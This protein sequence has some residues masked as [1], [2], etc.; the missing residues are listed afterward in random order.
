MIMYK[1]LIFS[2]LHT[3]RWMLW[4]DLIVFKKTFFQTLFD[5]LMWPCKVVLVFGYV[6]PALG[7]GNTYGGFNVISNIATVGVFTSVAYA[8]SILT[9]L[10]GDRHLDFYLTLPV[11][12]WVIFLREILF[13]ALKCAILSI[14]IYPVGL[15]LLG[16]RFGVV[17]FSYLNFG[18]IF[19][20][21]NIWFGGLALFL[22]GVVSRQQVYG[23][24]WGDATW[25]M[26]DLG[27][28]LFS[29]NAVNTMYPAF[30][31][32]LLFNPMSYA[33]EGLRGA[34]FGA[35]TA[36]PFMHCVVALILAFL[37]FCSI[38]SVALSKKMDCV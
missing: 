13:C 14:S 36:L 27:C 23:S 34:V 9:D 11:P 33:M 24:W 25:T 3:L 8:S 16:H 18:L 30:A 22:A 28:F 4:R 12:R 5:S 19:L 32:I 1:S 7:L 29:W 31:N 35:E 10:H 37:F 38:G 20:L 2:S 17:Q 21:V 6:M 15:M 26:W